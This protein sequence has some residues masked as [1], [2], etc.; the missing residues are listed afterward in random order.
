MISLFFFSVDGFML[1]FA[2]AR[3]F[4]NLLSIKKLQPNK[5]LHHIN[6]SLRFYLAKLVLFRFD[7]AE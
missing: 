6:T 5:V 4:T 2:G 7:E 3:Y 1:Q